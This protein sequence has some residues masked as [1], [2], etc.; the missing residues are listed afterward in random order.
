MCFEEDA[1]CSALALKAL[2][3][4]LAS[5]SPAPGAASPAT[6][7]GAGAANASVP[8]GKVSGEGKG[9]AAKEVKE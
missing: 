3:A 1:D 9:E 5:G 8:G 6:T 4:R 7:T 2:D